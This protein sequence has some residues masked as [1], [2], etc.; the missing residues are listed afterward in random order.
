MILQ[1]YLFPIRLNLYTDSL[2]IFAIILN[3]CGMYNTNCVHS[4]ENQH[5]A[6]AKTKA[7]ISFAVMVKLIMPL[8]SL[9]R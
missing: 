3:L 7:Q 8:F 1:A 4:W 2:K 6:Y 9:H 5:L